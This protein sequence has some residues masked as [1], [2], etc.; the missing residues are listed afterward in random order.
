MPRLKENRPIVTDADLY[1]A[2]RITPELAAD[3]LGIGYTP[4]AARVLARSGKIGSEIPGS[5]RVHI[6]I[7]KLISFKS[8]EEDTDAKYRAMARAFID[9]GLGEIAS[10]VAVAIIKVLEEE[11]HYS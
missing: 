3:Y 10:K 9:E 6:Q 5:N 8:G 11:V 7:A 2:D 4:Q 1:K